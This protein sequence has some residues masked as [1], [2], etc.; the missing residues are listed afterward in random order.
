MSVKPHIPIQALRGRAHMPSP[1]MGVALVALVLAL[2]GV[3]Y[4]A[5]PGADGTIT[6][7]VNTA[8]GALR[9]IDTAAARG[10]NSGET[11]LTW[12]DGI[13]GKVA[14]ADRLDGK[15]STAFLAQG[16]AAG[17]SLTG[18]YPDPSLKRDAVGGF[19]IWDGA[20]DSSDIASKL[21][22]VDGRTHKSFEIPFGGVSGA[23]IRDET[24]TGVDVAYSTLSGAHVSN[25]SL[26]GADVADNSLTGNDVNESTL[27]GLDG[28]DSFN[29]YCDP[30]NSSGVIVCGT[31][32]FTVGRSMQVLTLF[33]HKIGVGDGSGD[34][35][36]RLDGKDTSKTDLYAP[37][38]VGTTDASV[39]DVIA[40]APGTH[41]LELVCGQ[42]RTDFELE[43]IR[44]AAVELGMD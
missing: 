43:N 10:C 28:H 5:I 16:A 37:E 44:I 35:R 31:L 12:K 40:V 21:T 9:V 11:T 4:A 7:C 1:A 23:E 18:S 20:F 29:P 34:C 19:E 32:S 2:G 33:N 36:T 17:G 41:T 42:T 30:T 27:S 15:D 38:D 25:S 39:I 13:T 26:S 24:V 3:T 8:N 6:G 22:T 14:D